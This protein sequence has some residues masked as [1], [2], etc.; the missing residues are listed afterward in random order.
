MFRNTSVLCVFG[1]ALV[2]CMSTEDKMIADQFSGKNLRGDGVSMNINADGTFTGMVGNRLQ[3]DFAGTWKISGGR[4]CR[5]I[6]EPSRLAGSQCQDLTINNNG[7]VT[8]DGR[9]GP[10]TYTLR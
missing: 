10:A 5:T 4:W 9:S 2:G 8:I 7:T 6:S 3:D 1:V